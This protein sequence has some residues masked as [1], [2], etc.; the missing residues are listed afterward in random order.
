MMVGIRFFVMTMAI[1][2]RLPLLWSL[3]LRGSRCK[4]DPRDSVAGRTFRT[5]RACEMGALW[6]FWV[7]SGSTSE[8]KIA[9]ERL[10]AHCG[11][12]FFLMGKDI[13][14]WTIGIIWTLSSFFRLDSL[15]DVLDIA[16]Q[17]VAQVAEP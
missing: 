2:I 11:I 1:S 5:V 15:V 13:E 9:S 4:A 12:R 10:T 8:R 6:V 17:R 3:L 7:V 16:Q 14:E